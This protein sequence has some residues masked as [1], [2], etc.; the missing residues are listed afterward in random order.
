MP[1][2]DILIKNATIVDGTGSPPYKGGLAING[3]RI[4]KI[5]KDLGTREK[6][7]DARGKIVSPG[8]IDVHN[9]RALR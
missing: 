4:T 3:E 2:H 9:A 5:G 8:F 1:D 6:T 7:I